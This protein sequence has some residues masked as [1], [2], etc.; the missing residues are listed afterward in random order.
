[1]SL[2]QIAESDYTRAASLV[3]RSREKLLCCAAALAMAWCASPVLAGGERRFLLSEAQSPR[4][5]YHALDALRVDPAAVYRI[6]TDSRVILRRGIATLSFEEGKLAFLTALNG[7]VTGAVFSGRGHVLSAPRDQVEKQQMARFLGATVLDEDFTSAY[8][9]FTDSTFGE[10]QGQ[11][12]EAKSTSLPDEAFAEKWSATVAEVNNAHTLRIMDAYLTQNAKPYFYAGVQGLATGPFDLFYDLQRQEPFLLGQPRHAS[13][14]VANLEFYDVWVSCVLPGDSGAAPG[15]RALNYD[16]NTTIEP[17]KTLEG[18]ATVEIQAET[19]GERMLNFALSRALLVDRVTDEQGAALPFFQNEGLNPQVRDER[20]IDAIFVVIPRAAVAGE[21]FHL[22][23]HYR[24]NVIAD[25]GNGVLVV[26]ARDSWYPRLGDTA[27]FA[28]Y[29]LS[30]RWPRRMQLVATGTKL[31]ERVDGEYR[32]G[33]WRT[34]HPIS[35]AGFNLGEYASA[36]V[37]APTYSV[38]IYANRQLEQEL[39]NRLHPSSGSF[40]GLPGMR[41]GAGAEGDRSAAADFN[42]AQNPSPAEEMKQLGKEIDTSIRFYEK[43]S[44]AFPFRSLSV[45]Q[46][47][48]SF[49]QGWPGLLYLSTYAFLSP[50]VQRRMGLSE[51]GQ[52][53]FT[54]LVPYHEVAHQWWGNVVGWSSYRDQWID[55]AIAT[56]LSLMF[57]DSQKSQGHE[58]RVWLERFRKSLVTKPENSPEEAPA[59]SGALTLGSRLN[60]S[61]APRDYEVL[62]YSKGGWVLHMIREMLRQPRA[63]D[64]D[65]RFTKLM[66]TLSTKYA[67]RALSTADLQKEVEVVMTPQMD[68]EGGHSMEWF[69]EQWVHGTGIP[70]YHVEFTSHAGENGFLVKGTLLQTGVPRSFIAPVPLYAS[71]PNGRNIYLGTV[72]AEGAKTSFH[73]TTTVAPRR[74]VID[75]EMTLLCVS[76]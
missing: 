26:G 64:P 74:L 65:A 60:S 52:A 18:S 30:M 73:F 23:F 1:M 66:R 36:A 58:L 8:L 70:H 32:V 13:G 44:G 34:E 2:L 55:E 15:F 76:E 48:G 40:G 28:Q 11:L 68:L 75:P 5:L 20:G 72:T 71:G 27:D 46:M 25:A 53:H 49:G 57:A 37:T 14:P 45:S 10:L 61:K 17:S 43:F 35:V 39:S 19:G 41:R 54:E 51:S 4:E 63:Q 42:Y 22:H 59:E 9:R 16:V 69:F 62:I 3:C 24:G 50:D 29:E 12:R 7:Q 67:Y 38:E 31:D 6:D 56:Y 21:H 47:P 33:H